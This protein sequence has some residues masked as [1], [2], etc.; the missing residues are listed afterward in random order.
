L[1]RLHGV[2]DAALRLE[3][4]LAG[5]GIGGQGGVAGPRRSRATILVDLI[6][7]FLF[8]P[9]TTTSMV[10]WAFFIVMMSVNS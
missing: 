7:Y 3:N 6:R 4:L 8:L 5:G 1:T 10:L 2:A 9:S